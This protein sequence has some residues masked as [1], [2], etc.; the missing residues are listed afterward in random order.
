MSKP[1]EVTVTRYDYDTKETEEVATVSLYLLSRSMKEEHL[2]A[3]LDQWTNSYSSGLRRGERIGKMFQNSH[4]TLQGTLVNFALGLLKGISD[5]SEW[6]E[7][8]GWDEQEALERL[9]DPRNRTAVEAARKVVKLLESGDI[10]QQ[11]LI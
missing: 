9:T 2:Y 4:R 6:E 3:L 1:T 8:N 5:F 10:Y 11:P 7:K